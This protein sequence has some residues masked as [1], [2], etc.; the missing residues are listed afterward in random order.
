MSDPV[1]LTNA[2]SRLVGITDEAIRFFQQLDYNTNSVTNRVTQ[3]ESFCKLVKKIELQ[4]S[5]DNTNDQEQLDLTKQ[6]LLHC[7]KVIGKILSHLEWIDNGGHHTVTQQGLV[8]VYAELNKQE[9]KN[10]FEELHREQICQVAFRK[11]KFKP[12]A[13]A[14][15][16][17]QQSLE[18]S[19]TLKDRESEFLDLL[20]V[21]DP[22]G[23]RASLQSTRGHIVEGTCTWITNTPIY[24]SWLSNS[25]ASR[26][27]IIQGGPGKGKTM[28]A[29][30]LTEQLERLAECISTDTVLYFFCNQGNI[31]TNS[32]TAVLRGLIWQLCRL[33][34]QL[35]YYGLDKVASLHDERMALAT[36]SVEKLW[37]IFNA[38]T[39]DPSAGTVTCVLNGLDECD[40]SSVDALMDKFSELLSPTNTDR[41]NVRVLITRRSAQSYAGDSDPF[42]TLC[43]DSKFHESN[44]Q[45]VQRYIETSVHKIAQEYHWSREIQDQVQDTLSKKAKG[46]FLWATL[47]IHNA[48]EIPHDLIT[49]YLDNVS[50]NV[51]PIYEKI[52]LDIPREQQQRTR[53]LLSWITLAYHPLTLEELDV[54]TAI[55]DSNSET[56]LENLKACIKHCGSLLATKNETRKTSAGYETVQTIQL[57]HSSVGDY[58][59]RA[60]TDKDVDLEIFRIV[61]DND[62]ERLASRCLDIMNE[63]LPAWSEGKLEGDCIL[64]LPYATRLWFRHLRQC[65]Q[66]LADVTLANKALP[67]LSQNHSHRKLW[68]LYLSKFRAVRHTPIPLH[69]SSIE[70]YNMIHGLEEISGIIFFEKPKE[71]SSI[72][73]LHDLQLACL[74]GITA[75]VHKLLDNTHAIR[76]LKEANIRPWLY[77]HKTSRPRDDPII[78][79]QG[80]T[81]MVLSA[82]E[83]LAMTPL[84]LAVF[85]GHKQVASLLLDRFPRSSLRPD[86]GFILAA[87][88]SYCEADLV[89]LLIE[90]GVP[91]FEASRKFDGPISTAVSQRRLDVVKFLC[92]SEETIWAKKD[93]KVSEI[94]QALVC[95]IKDPITFKSD[96]AT[97]VQYA[98]VLLQGGGSP[99][100][101]NP[102]DNGH[103]LRH[104]KRAV[105]EFL[106][107]H[108]LPLQALG[109]LP[110]KQ[111]PLMLCISTHGSGNSNSDPVE[112]VQFL[113][114]SGASINQ[115]DLRGWTALHHV[116][117]QIALGRAKTDW[118]DRDDAE[119]YKLYQIASLLIAAGIDRDLED[120]KKRTA[121]DILRVVGAPIWNRDMSEYERHIRSKPLYRMSLE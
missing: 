116:A 59:L 49:A 44:V 46:S 41:R 27:L 60:T 106:H 7:H 45:D 104:W 107:H 76:Y 67:F 84:E 81:T 5:L 24:R 65:P 85:E 66:Q 80:V 98:S 18:Y 14:A 112:T 6:I 70:H 21:T 96:E 19:H 109:L 75:I 103:G 39:R 26:G 73:R 95:L 3:L 52:L 23:D 78:K 68:F 1:G 90:A 110:D 72:T 33:R 56:G 28:L 99:D 8:G 120:R 97:F 74:L 115:T 10:L 77:G 100:G 22:R 121:A 82:E 88:I 111:T 63:E 64:S 55:Q 101:A 57:F 93:S 47:S 2:A 40:E 92:S 62:H 58:L 20:F 53:L 102:G 89:K 35:M 71:A 43:L 4:P 86:S 12:L 114:T 38:M 34:P 51:T 118:E 25:G 9:I 29:I 31:N 48:K 105:M 61:P 11:S 16:S 91:K 79:V 42:S 83:V 87:A 94:T 69:P 119:E 50:E 108:G 36:G 30:Y 13:W 17:T 37:Q 54:L 15:N 32:A 113:L 117:N